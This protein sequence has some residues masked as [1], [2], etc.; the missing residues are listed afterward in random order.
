MWKQKREPEAKVPEAVISYG[1]RSGKSKM[2]KPDAVN[3]K[4]VKA[5]AEAVVANFK[6]LEAE[7]EAEALH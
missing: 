6:K 7:V 3:F 2:K 1:S 5:E 4:V